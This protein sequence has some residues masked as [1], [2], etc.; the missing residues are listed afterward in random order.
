MCFCARKRR[1]I[2]LPTGRPR[3]TWVPACPFP[4]RESVRTSLLPPEV[5]RTQGKRSTCALYSAV[6]ESRFSTNDFGVSAGQRESTRWPPAP[7]SGQR[8]L[9]AKL[10]GGPDACRQSAKTRVWPVWC[11][12]E[13]SKDR[14]GQP[15]FAFFDYRHQ[16]NMWG[17]H[18][19]ADYRVFIVARTPTMLS[20]V[21]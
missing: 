19:Q 11:A 20:F 16:A 2:T 3:R 1:D 12:L 13:D 15:P 6:L 21:R 9:C 17:R 7:S 5:L 10:P 8:G 14:R 18:P 4:Q